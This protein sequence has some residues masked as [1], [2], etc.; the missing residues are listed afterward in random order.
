MVSRL[1]G[2]NICPCVYDART[3]CLELR[4][5]VLGFEGFA[6]CAGSQCRRNCP[7]LPSWW[8]K[9][10]QALNYLSES[11]HEGL[12]SIG[13]LVLLTVSQEHGINQ[14]CRGPVLW[15]LCSLFVL[16]LST[17]FPGHPFLS[18][19]RG[20]DDWKCDMGNLDPDDCRVEVRPSPHESYL[21]QLLHLVKLFLSSS[22]SRG[23][24]HSPYRG[25]TFLLTGANICLQH[26][27]FHSS[28]ACHG[29][30]CV[31]CCTLALPRKDSGL[32][33]YGTAVL[34][35]HRLQFRHLCC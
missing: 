35:S 15:F 32:S 16:I 28:K 3:P 13:G 21:K 24:P 8:V 20:V 27:I 4:L 11:S 14:D 2:A 9:I 22:M 33:A 1:A 7:S 12:P 29:W 18:L 26:I 5:W 23:K 19:V 6:A 34:K 17:S 10:M 30:M 31:L 25:Q